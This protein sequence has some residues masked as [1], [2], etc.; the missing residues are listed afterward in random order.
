MRP[1]LERTTHMRRHC[2]CT[3]P[4]LR[5]RGAC[6]RHHQAAAE[7]AAATRSRRLLAAA[8]HAGAKRCAASAR[9]RLEP[10]ARTGPSSGC[11]RPRSP[12]RSPPYSRAPAACAPPSR[13]R[14]RAACGTTW[15]GA[16]RSAAAARPR[17]T[18]TPPETPA[19][20]GAGRA[21]ASPDGAVRTGPR[22]VRRRADALE[23]AAAG[24]GAEARHEAHPHRLVQLLVSEPELAQECNRRR[25][26]R[27][28]G[29][30]RKMRCR[31]RDNQR[32]ATGVIS[33]AVGA[34]DAP[35]LRPAADGPS[36]C[37]WRAAARR[38]APVASQRGRLRDRGRGAAGCAPVRLEAPPVRLAHDHV[39]LVRAEAQR[40]HRGHARVPLLLLPRRRRCRSR[41][42]PEPPGSVNGTWSAAGGGLRPRQRLAVL[43]ETRGGRG[44]G[45]RRQHGRCAAC[46][47]LRQ[48]LR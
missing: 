8:L 30:S 16:P 15:P 22:L 3:Q 21:P 5:R 37:A 32:G 19:G 1:L 20:G 41:R 11:T 9:A 39:R 6:A 47:S 18:P 17:C 27:T 25:H 38:R 2:P 28:G 7:Q 10:R 33:R 29:R 36:P 43:G 35:P 31:T 14:R 44:G 23:P 4:R 24:Q 45:R 40:G 12:L 34:W 46:G 13:R 26:L 42:R 48:L